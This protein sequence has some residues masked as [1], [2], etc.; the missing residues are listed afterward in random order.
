ME[1][2]E[3][4]EE[5]QQ[6]PEKRKRVKRTAVDAFFAEQRD[7]SLVK[8][9]I[10]AK[11]F[12][13]WAR[14]MIARSM[15]GRIVYLDLY[16]GTGKYSDGSSSTPLLVLDSIIDDEK[17]RNGVVSIFNE[18]N[19]DS[20]EKL[21]GAIQTHPGVETLRYAPQILNDEVNDA[22]A[23]VFAKT[24]MVPSLLFA[25]P[26]GYK[27]LTRDLLRAILKDWGSDCI[28]FFNYNRIYMGLRNPIVAGHI[29][30]IFG[31][32][33]A[34]WL[35]ANVTPEM[36]PPK[37]EA[38]I[39]HALREA[40]AEI[41][42]AYTLAFRFRRSAARTSHHLVFVTKNVLG[43]DI[44]KQ[45][46]ASESSTH[47]QDVASFEFLPKAG[48]TELELAR[49]LDELQ[50]ELLQRYAGKAMTVKQLIDDHNIGTPY[51][52]KNYKDALKNLRAAGK[53]QVYR[54]K[55]FQE[56]FMPDDVLVTFEEPS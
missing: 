8:A 25:D 23:G 35:R 22:A 26:F 29:D 13:A 10:V 1:N 12:V 42:G 37:R 17:L 45:V 55:P 3:E 4:G 19:A 28:F 31:K 11:Y 34:D 27:G 32:E 5:Q 51:V 21:K 44:M 14:I 6:P 16:A 47:P 46:M 15:S 43:H 52:P 18:M 54:E 7:Q 56:R 33:R 48:Q 20:Y 38:T 41:D 2:L 49:P 24:K 36:D 40:M 50:E 30:A 9:R 39:L 53:I